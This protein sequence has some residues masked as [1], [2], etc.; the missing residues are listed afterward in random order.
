[1]RANGDFGIF[2]EGVTGGA[3]RRSLLWCRDRDQAVSLSRIDFSDNPIV[4]SV[5]SWS[6]MGYTGK[7]DYFEPDFG[8]YD[9]EELTSPW[10]S[11]GS[12]T[13]DL[14]IKGEA[15][16]C[17]LGAA[18]VEEGELIYDN[19]EDESLQPKICVVLGKA[20]KSPSRVE[21]RN[22]VLIVKPKEG[23]SLSPGGVPSYER[24]GAGY[25][26]GKCIYQESFSVNIY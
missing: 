26:P 4:T 12:T 2:D 11:D 8:H 23:S 21:Q 13:T 9:W 7:I 1:M 10:L 25:L 24:I 3:L 6:W 22:F 16:L 15:R 17:D 19:P 18:T 5:P 20:Q 14:A